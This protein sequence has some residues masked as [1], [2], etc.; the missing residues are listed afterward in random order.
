M[1]PSQLQVICPKCQNRLYVQLT[2]QTQGFTCP[3]CNFYGRI[4]PQAPQQP[5]QY[6]QPQQY[7]QQYQQPTQPTLPIPTQSPIQKE[8]KKSPAVII[9]IIVIVA[10]I[11]IAGVLYVLLT[12]EEDEGG[13]LEIKRVYHEPLSPGTDDQVDFYAEIV[14]CPSSY[15]VVYN[16]EVYN[17]SQLTS[18][19]EGTMY[20]ASGSK[21]LWRH[22]ELFTSTGFDT[23]KEV[24]FY[25]EIFDVDWD[26]ELEQTPIMTSEIDS[27]II[28]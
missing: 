8:G 19:G 15:D 4:S 16:V 6:Q 14:N 18:Y 10:V 28:S 21:N 20:K 5:P 2:S 25:V 17:G 26:P 3:F 13:E 1:Q 7:P 11:I 23:G 9:G 24:K 12:G 27:L 22:S